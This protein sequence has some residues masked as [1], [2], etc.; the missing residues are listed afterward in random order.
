[1]Q[2]ATAGTAPSTADAAVMRFIAHPPTL[3]LTA[4]V[5][6]AS[7]SGESALIIMRAVPSSMVRCQPQRPRAHL[8]SWRI[9]SNTNPMFARMVMN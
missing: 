1:V 6:S 9:C 2:P 5:I 4:L 3:T 8:D 7:Y